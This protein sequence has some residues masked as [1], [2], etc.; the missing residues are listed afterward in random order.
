MTT[1]PS[2]YSPMTDAERIVGESLRDHLALRMSVW[3]FGRF[4]ILLGIGLL[5]TGG[6]IGFSFSHLLLTPA[7]TGTKAGTSTIVLSLIVA[8]LM[9]AGVSAVGF[10]VVRL[11]LGMLAS[12]R[13]K[14]NSQQT[15]ALIE[16]E[17]AAG[18]VEVTTHTIVACCLLSDASFKPRV[19]GLPAG[20]LCQTDHGYV[21][22]VDEVLAFGFASASQ[23][24]LPAALGSRISISVLPRSRRLLR[25]ESSGSVLVPAGVLAAGDLPD[26]ARGFQLL[27]E[28][29]L[30]D[31][32]REAFETGHA[33]PP[34]RRSLT[35]Q[36]P[37][38]VAR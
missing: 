22:L 20:Y 11:V 2:P 3:H 12:G 33:K 38:H 4:P 9:I 24:Q 15:L 31:E 37:L 26:F 19:K 21:A 29:H 1:S 23:P 14:A 18:Q 28:D 25:L 17:L 32:Q 36:G 13:G 35:D 27:R 16:A 7:P 8:A 30:S 5:I 34:T 6:I 10:G